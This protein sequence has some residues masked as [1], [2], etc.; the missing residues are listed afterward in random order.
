MSA[1][2]RV[3]GHVRVALDEGHAMKNTSPARRNLER[4]RSKAAASDPEA[5]WEMGAAYENG[6]YD[7][8]G[9][10][11]LKSDL[12]QAVQFYR[13]AAALGQQSA[14]LNLANLLYM[15][16]GVARDRV[17]ALRLEKRAAARGNATGA[18]NAAVT[19]KGLGRYRLAVKWFRKA[20]SMGDH[21]ALLELAKAE[22]AG[23][24]TRRSVAGA[25]KRLAFVAR[26]RRVSQTE[27][28]EA[29]L[30]MARLYLDGWLVPRS[31]RKARQW[32]DVAAR[33]G[34]ASAIV[35]RDE[36]FS[37]ELGG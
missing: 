20:A 19:Y 6:L 21:S 35:W 17:A 4:V 8:D 33:S 9:H 22:L 3:A 30:T 34:S 25:V 36:E 27:Q 24:G 16:R 31:R 23:Q 29:C 18:F 15:G 5:L 10:E 26:S 7:A 12:A 14:M 11:I 2:P 13:R 37:D 28:H 1:R 32:L